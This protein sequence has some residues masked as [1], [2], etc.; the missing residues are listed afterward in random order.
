MQSF[1]KMRIYFS[2]IRFWYPP[3]T[4]NYLP[5]YLYLPSLRT[6]TQRANRWPTSIFRGGIMGVVKP[7]AEFFSAFPHVIEAA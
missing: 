1:M 5:R 4:P 2:L 7:R 3:N 6:N